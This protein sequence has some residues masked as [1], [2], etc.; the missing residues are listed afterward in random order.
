M[1]RRRFSL[2]SSVCLLLLVVAL[3]GCGE[4]DA[5]IA[6]ATATAPSATAT[7]T[8]PAAAAPLTLRAAE[9]VLD[10]RGFAPLTERDWRPDQQLKV[11]IGVRRG[12]S[13]DGAQQAFL[14]A[15][16]RFIGT[17]T[18][19]RSGRITV[20]AQSDD[21]VTLTYALYRP[22]DSIERPSGGTADVTYVW[23]GARLTPED[24]IPPADPSASLGRR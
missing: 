12:V 9:Q 23:D 15:G 14:F 4:E 5:T 13:D 7:T 2:I 21:R 16:D 20:A 6:P 10:G 11:L 1:P 22:G 19:D 18:K 8:A 24:P 17:D 3:V